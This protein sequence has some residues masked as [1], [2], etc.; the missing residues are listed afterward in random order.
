MRS[1]SV[2]IKKVL[3]CVV[4]LG[5]MGLAA[6]GGG[7]GGS[8]T[9]NSSSSAKGGSSSSSSSAS[10]GKAVVVYFS[11]SGNT[12]RAA[13]AIAKGLNTPTFELTPQQPYTDD[14]LDWTD[15]DS[16]VI[17]EHENESLQDVK[18]ADTK[19]S[20]WDTYNT[21]YLGFPI[22]WMAPAWP[23][24][25][26]VKSNDFTGKTIIP[27]CTSTS[28]GIDDSASTLQKMA[29]TGTWL[30]GHRFSGSVSEKDVTDW[31]SQTRN[32]AAE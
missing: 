20:D 22:W 10:N 15:P 9:S 31:L 5:M 28:S 23:V 24:N 26:F 17:R 1:A 2:L 12:K 27:F 16:R 7:A 14:D 6:C 18:L 13:E 32:G 4:G 19:V 30:T 8:S 11:A 3:A 29:G 21:V 25:D